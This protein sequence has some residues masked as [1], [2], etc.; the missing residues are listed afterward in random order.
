MLYK[1]FL[2]PVFYQVD[3]EWIHDRV[4]ALGKQLAHTSGG[5]SLL[6]KAY[7]PP[8]FAELSQTLFGYPFS[9]PVGLAAGFDKNIQLP[10]VIRAL[11]FSFEEAGSISAQAATGNA[12]PRLFRL[13]RDQALMNRMGLNN[14]GVSALMPA[15]RSLPSDWPVGISVVKTPDPVL[16]GEAGFADFETTIRAI[17]GD[18]AYVSLNISCPNT[19]DGKTFEEPQALENLLA[20]L[21]KVEA[22]CIQKTGRE[23]RPWLLK[24]SP[25]LSETQLEELFAVAC[26]YHIAGWVACNTTSRPT[27]LKTP[28]RQVSRLGAG[29]ISGVPV[30][31]IAT[32]TLSKL[33]QLG[34]PQYQMILIGVGG[35]HDVDSAWEKI[36]HGASLLQLYT[37]L[38]Y[39]GPGVLKYICRGLQTKLKQHGFSHLQEAVGSAFR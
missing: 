20:R 16:Q 37:G 6:A 21:R 22:E 19:L 38:I 5:L 17:H 4:L 3:A 30:Q 39:E 10:A 15:I 11:G 29:G 36:T 1:A 2:R 23:P 28:L 33:Y 8:H 13:P 24:I 18:G 7:A 35:V 34:A 32:Q 25:D 9:H 14:A 27:G 12:K 31:A 26:Q